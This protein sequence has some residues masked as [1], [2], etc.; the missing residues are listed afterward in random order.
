MGEL[1]LVVRYRRQSTWARR[2]Q[3]HWLSVLHLTLATMGH[4]ANWQATLSSSTSTDKFSIVPD[5]K[6]SGSIIKAMKG[7]MEHSS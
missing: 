5:G 1:R 2:W 3:C 7:R 6:E 4:P